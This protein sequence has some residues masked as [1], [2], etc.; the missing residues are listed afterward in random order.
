MT[1]RALAKYLGKDESGLY[2]MRKNHPLQFNLL[3]LGWTVHNQ[4][5]QSKKDKRIIK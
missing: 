1:M 5:E 2:K 4:L 3:W